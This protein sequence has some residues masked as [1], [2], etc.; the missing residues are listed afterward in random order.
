MKKHHNKYLLFVLAAMAALIAVT[1][2]DR[3]TAASTSTSFRDKSWKLV[4]LTVT[5]AIDWDLNGA[6]DR[7]IFTLL[8][9]C[10]QDDPLNLK[11]ITRL[12]ATRDRCNVMTML[13]KK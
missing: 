1:C 6:A 3:G 11:T 9:D 10:E 12:F 7:D 2:T 13:W 4:K 8:D 5:P